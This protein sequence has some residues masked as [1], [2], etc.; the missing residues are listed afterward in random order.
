MVRKIKNNI[1]LLL[2]M[3][4]IFPSIVKIEHHHEHS[5]LV[6]SNVIGIHPF[7]EKCGICSFE[8]SFFLSFTEYVSL[9]K[10]NPSDNYF[11]SYNSPYNS[12]LSSFFFL[13]R[14][15]PL[16]FQISTD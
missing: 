1:A 5:C 16:T 8:F 15:P 12:N 4:F 7:H 11:I 13:L 9:Q 6:P 3:V 2:L 10:E 14:A